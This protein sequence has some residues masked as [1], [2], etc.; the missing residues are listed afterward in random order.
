[1]KDVDGCELSSPS[2]HHC[3]FQVVSGVVPDLNTPPSDQQSNNNED[4]GLFRACDFPTDP[5]STDKMGDMVVLLDPKS[6]KPWWRRWWRAFMKSIG[7]GA[8]RM[9]ALFSSECPH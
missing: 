6:V 5:Y 9:K 1:M 8:A 3:F 7:S 2:S 4:L